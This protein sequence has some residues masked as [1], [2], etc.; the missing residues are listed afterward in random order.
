[1]KVIDNAKIIDKAI[2]YS[3]N[4]IKCHIKLIPTGFK[5]GLIISDLIDNTFFWFIED[6]NLKIEQR[7]FLSEIFDINDYVEEEK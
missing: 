4:N 3:T 5:N 6:R 2:F 7:L 1:M